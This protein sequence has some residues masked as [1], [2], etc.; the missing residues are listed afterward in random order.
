[1]RTVRAFGFLIYFLLFGCESKI[2]EVGFLD[3]THFSRS[4]LRNSGY[5]VSHPPTMR[6][7]VDEWY[8]KGDDS[9]FWMGKPDSLAP[10]SN[11]FGIRLGFPDS[12]RTMGWDLPIIERAQSSV[13]DSIII[14]NIRKS[15]SGYYLAEAQ[16]RDIKFLTTSTTL[17]GIDSMIACISSLSSR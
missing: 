16:L 5:F 17:A 13:M 11:G 7:D 9:S 14:W 1:M 10:F 2:R 4:K 15:D 12:A 3:S 6:L 8:Q